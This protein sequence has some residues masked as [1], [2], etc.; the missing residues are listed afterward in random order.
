[1]TSRI[2]QFGTSRFLQAHAALFVHE[3]RQAGQDAGPITVVQISGSSSRNGRVAAFGKPGGY[4]VTLRGI[5][6]RQPVDRTVNVTSVERGLSATDDWDELSRIF[7]T[8]AE[9]VVSTPAIR[10]IRRGRMRTVST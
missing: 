7:S 8:E 6:A 4:P 2:I 5:S 10:D 3:A 9:F 1:M